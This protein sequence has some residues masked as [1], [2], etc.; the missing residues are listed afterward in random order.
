M[1]RTFRRGGKTFRYVYK[2]GKK[3]AKFLI[4][5]YDLRPSDLKKGAKRYFALRKLFLADGMSAE[6]FDSMVSDIT[7]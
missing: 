6:E 7:K 3:S 2:G 5:V 1:G 4:E